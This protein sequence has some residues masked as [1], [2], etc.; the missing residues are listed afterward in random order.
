MSQP[1]KN[2]EKSALRYQLPTVR[3]RPV[4]QLK[5]ALAVG[6]HMG[7]FTSRQLEVPDVSDHR[8]GLVIAFLHSCGL[9]MR[10]G[11][12]GVYRATP[13]ARKIAEAWGRSETLGRRELAIVLGG[14]WFAKIA[15]EELGNHA[16]QRVALANR[17]LAAARA[18]ESRRG[19]VEVLI[20]WLL[21]ARLILPV[22]DGYVRWN[23][24]AHTAVPAEAE[25]TAETATAGELK[26][27]SPN[28]CDS[29]QGFDDTFAAKRPG[30]SQQARSES[31][32]T[33]CSSHSAGTSRGTAADPSADA[34]PSP[35]QHVSDGRPDPAASFES[36]SPKP[37]PEHPHTT[38]SRAGIAED[39]MFDSEDTPDAQSTPDSGSL[40]RGDVIPSQTDRSA[41]AQSAQP[42]SQ[43]TELAHLGE[44]AGQPIML[45]ELLQLSE[46]ELLSMYRGLRRFVDVTT[47]AGSSGIKF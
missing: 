3:T 38:V 19:E 36:T 22:R 21:E 4:D 23:A 14:T 35:A 18:P 33:E 24:D 6:R 16:G 17:L 2:R 46:E 8:K 47:G 42:A 30:T 20:M 44:L 31:T 26:K 37:L 29:D 13:A 45:H 32:D 15:R 11:G 9:L 27:D 40:L 28:A 5:V 41:G 39:E 7:V 43:L 10:G 1:R 12:R 34:I 25:K